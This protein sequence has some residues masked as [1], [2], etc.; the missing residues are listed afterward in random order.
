[1][2]YT[3]LSHDIK[4]QVYERGNKE[5][6]TL[7]IILHG[8][9][10]SGAK[11]LMNLS[12][13]QTLTLE[14]HCIYFDQ[15]GSGESHYDLQKGLLAEQVCKDVH[16]VIEDSRKRWNSKNIILWG[17]SYGGL[18]ACM[19]MEY[20]GN[21]NGLILSSP[22][23]VFQRAQAVAFYQRSKKLME[24]KLPN[25]MELENITPTTCEPE[26]ELSNP[27]FL[28][29]VFSSLNPSNSLKHIVAMASWFYQYDATNVCRNIHVPT[30][31]MIGKEDEVCDA[32]MLMQAINN[33]QNPNF[34][35]CCFPSC[36]HAVFED[37]EEEFIKHIQ[38]FIKVINLKI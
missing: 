17:G 14:Y 36:G 5:S 8:G 30:L 25:T 6:D 26:E 20:Y 9:P 23:I 12:S 1:M 24:K 11:P 13:F 33:I 28:K 7:L 38:S 2:N 16:I 31:L 22:A 18:L 34:K 3:I 32:H 29:F 10:G 27:N 19:Y 37:C 4:L 21:V 35:A 15:R